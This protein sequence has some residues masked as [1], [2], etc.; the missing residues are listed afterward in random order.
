MEAQGTPFLIR[1]FLLSDHG[2][3]Y[4]GHQGQ[5]NEL[6]HDIRFWEAKIVAKEQTWK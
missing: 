3:D 5:A 2:A 1:E 4:D 6:F